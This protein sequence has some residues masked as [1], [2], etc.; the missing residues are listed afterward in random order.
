M[1]GGELPDDSV[2][3]AL[4]RGSGSRPVPQAVERARLD[5]NIMG[6]RKTVETLSI[7]VL[8]TKREIDFED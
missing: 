5:P 7:V 8:S 4:A 6:K 2:L 3:S 1:A